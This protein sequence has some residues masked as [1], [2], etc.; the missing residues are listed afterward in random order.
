MAKIERWDE[1][2]PKDR[3][4]FRERVNTQ[5]NTSHGHFVTAIKNL[6]EQLNAEKVSAEVK[7]AY[8]VDAIF[9]ARQLKPVTDAHKC[10][11]FQSQWRQTGGTPV[12]CLLSALATAAARGPSRLQVIAAC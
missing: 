6:Q 1:A 3:D 12:R 8:T 9:M 11:N 4:D 10:S 5:K 7:D 2:Q